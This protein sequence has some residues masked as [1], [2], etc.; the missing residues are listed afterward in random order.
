MFLNDEN[1]KEFILDVK[2]PGEYFGEM[3]LDEGPRSASV[4]TMQPCELAV[5]S[6]NDFRQLVLGH[7]HMALSVIKN[8]IQMARGLNEN[9]RSLATLDVYGRVSRLLLDLAVK[10]GEKLLVPGKLKQ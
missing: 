8:L 4:V 6:G 1:G 9:V 7:P 5:V 2:G 10:Q 3:V